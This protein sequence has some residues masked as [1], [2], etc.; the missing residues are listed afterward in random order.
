MNIL[1]NEEETFVGYQ[2]SNYV[3]VP[4]VPL[5]AERTNDDDELCFAIHIVP[6]SNY[7]IGKYF[8]IIY[9]Q[10]LLPLHNWVATCQTL[11]VS[12]IVN[13][14]R[15]VKTNQTWALLQDYFFL[16]YDEIEVEFDLVLKKTTVKANMDNTDY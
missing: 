6:T 4:Y 1:Q 8:Q 7:T 14:S 12:Q 3:F 10:N 5:G 11:H 16:Q 15:S 9:S 2:C 13:N